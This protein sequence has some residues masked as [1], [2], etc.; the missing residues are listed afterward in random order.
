MD[1]VGI[2]LFLLGLLLYVATHRRQPIFLF[3]SGVGLGLIVG[4]LWAMV[5][6][7]NVLR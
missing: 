3:F 2:A 6:V 1:C 5:I 7:N 4:A